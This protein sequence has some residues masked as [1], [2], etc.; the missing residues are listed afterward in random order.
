[1]LK[2]AKDYGLYP[3]GEQDAVTERAFSQ[4]LRRGLGSAIRALKNSEDKT[5]YRGALLRCCLRDI[6]YDWQSEGTKGYYLYDA[7]LASGEPEYYEGTII[8]KF[9]SRCSNGVFYQMVAILYRFADDGNEDAKEALRSKYEYFVSKKGRLADNI[10]VDEGAQWDEVVFHMMHIDGFFAF[11]RYAEDVGKI[12]LCNP[13]NRKMYNEWFEFRARNVFGV[14]RVEAF[15]TLNY[16]R[17]AAIKALVD[18]LRGRENERLR[19][20]TRAG[21][22][23]ITVASLLCIAREEATSQNSRGR[24]VGMIR[25]FVREA[26][27]FEIRDLAHAALR[28]EQETVKAL[29]L[30]AFGS[31]AVLGV[32]FPLDIAPLIEYAWSDSALLA[33]AAIDCLKVFKDKR[34]HEL[35]VQLLEQKGLCSSALSLLIKNYRKVDDSL[36]AGLIVKLP[37]I[38]HDIQQAVGGIYCSHRSKSALSILLHVYQKGDC[39]FCRYYIVRAM[40]HCGVL[41]YD[42]LQECLYDS[43]DDTRNFA[44]KLI[45][46]ASSCLLI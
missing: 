12:L 7:L 30:M 37:H 15:F 32:S 8:K 1:M 4:A 43:Y 5:A 6:S 20:Q 31:K 26:S 24:I 33:K 21:Q 22:G 44:R 27:D 16:E 23:K 40:R 34:I 18:M 41:S 25:Q 45:A 38:P 29:L 28:E 17:S 36:I 35:A 14:K 9:L 19:L 3:E 2:L 42:I 39:S 11:K 46:H 13:E 10:S